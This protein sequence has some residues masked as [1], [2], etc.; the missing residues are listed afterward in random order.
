MSHTTKTN[1]YFL[2]TKEW[3]DFWLSA[4]V[5]GHDY[6]HIINEEN[7]VIVSAFLYK[8]PWHLN[9]EFL[10]LPKGPVISC[11]KK[12]SS[13]KISKALRGFWVKVI[14]YAQRHAI[15]YVKADFD[16]A[17]MELMGADN[18]ESVL[19]LLETSFAPD[20]KTNLPKV[21]IIPDTKTI[22]YLQTMEL[23]ATTLPKPPKGWELQDI[24]KWY[25]SSDVFWA[26]TNQ[27][28]RRYNKKSCKNKDFTINITKST[29]QFEK[30]WHV[31][32]DTTK[33][34][35][36]ATHPREYFEKLY[37]CEFSHV[38][39][40]DYKN[41]TVCTWFGIH[42]GNTLLYL[43]GGNLNEGLTHKAQYLMHIAALKLLKELGLETYDLGGYDKEKGFGK[44]KEGYRGTIRTFLGP[45]DIVLESRKYHFT[46]RFAGAAK[47]LTSWLR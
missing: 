4:M 7:G 40:I 34:Q 9:Q 18:N 41:E 2:Q 43:Y 26:S 20:G 12:I 8:Y 16:D 30:F 22:Q 10:Y 23:D 28:I 13:D 37:H 1:P 27:N 42:S 46:S 45:V 32:S 14:E 29:E 31:Y 44:F 11:P 35:K 17:V 3:A 47:T 33:R 15:T 6:A 24:E 36:F 19:E 25:Q 38:I 21:E 39:N 5:E